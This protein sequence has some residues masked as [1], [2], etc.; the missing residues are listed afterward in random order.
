MKCI[1]TKLFPKHMAWT[2][3][4]EDYFSPDNLC[5]TLVILKDE[6]AYCHY[7]DV[8]LIECHRL[9]EKISQPY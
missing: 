7:K 8:F 3:L 6:Y 5:S 4:S 2:L 9:T 1:C